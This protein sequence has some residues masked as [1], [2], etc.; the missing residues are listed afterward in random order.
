MTTRLSALCALM[1]ISQPALACGGFFCDSA[2]L[3]S[4]P[5]SAR[6]DQ[7]SERILF[8]VDD[9]AGE[10]EVH[11][12][13][14]FQGEASDFAWI[15]PVPEIPELFTSVG[16]LFD[17]IQAD[18]EPGWVVS[19]KIEGECKQPKP[20][21][22]RRGGNDKDSDDSIELSAADTDAPLDEGGVVVAA[23]KTVGPYDTVTLQAD[24]SAS[25][26]D[27]LQLNDFDIPSDLGPKL[28][29]YL[30][31]GSWFV[32]LK[33]G[34]QQSTGDLVPLGMRY[35][36]SE[37]VIPLQ[38]T[39]VAATPDMRLETY[40]VGEHRAVPENYLHVVVN[41]FAI[42]WLAG[43]TNYN[44]I[45]TRAA[46]EAG[47]QAF[48]TDFA[49]PTSKLAGR[50]WSSGAYDLRELREQTEIFGA[51]NAVVA[52]GIPISDGT[53]PFL[54]AEIPFP[55]GLAQ[56]GL[57]D[58]GFWQCLVDPN[59]NWQFSD[60]APLPV[61][62]D[63]LA[64]SLLEWTEAMKHVQEMFD[65][66]A[67]LTRLRSSVSPDEMT[68]DPLFVL[69]PDM[70]D[71]EQI[72]TAVLVTECDK[73]TYVGD[74]PRRFELSD[75]RFVR[76]PSTNEGFNW[77]TYLESLTSYAAEQVQDAGRSGEPSTISD[78]RAEINFALAALNAEVEAEIAAAGCGCSTVSP[79]GGA[80]LMLPGLLWLARRR[81]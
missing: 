35:P 75:G 20:V 15:V 6:V 52:A 19:S 57:D 11:V 48:A 62:G 43:G 42:N 4:G 24:D 32:A 69:N 12:E 74:A 17:I 1:S 39:A 65:E 3:I 49:G 81:D 45:I 56:G 60:Q 13:I 68:A 78:R 28:D 34:K 58:L 18:T 76:V 2:P 63:A 36:G 25:L 8:L 30:A 46:D 64:D 16:D 54:S 71:V 38:L 10:V 5:Q 7:T 70:A 73:R 80:F 21:R 22:S 9:A 61:D 79:T 51:L 26:L 29:P 55:Q 47:G 23:Q 44:E 72:R 67:T 31:G 59:C 27:W 33:M 37:P 53:A 41:P 77:D 14:G 40:V 66:T 50:F